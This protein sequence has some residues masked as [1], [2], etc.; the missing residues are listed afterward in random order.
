[1]SSRSRQYTAGICSF[2]TLKY[3]TE[4]IWPEHLIEMWR[5][6]FPCFF[7]PQTSYCFI[8][9]NLISMATLPLLPKSL[10]IFPTMTLR[11]ALMIHPNNS[12][13]SLPPQEVNWIQ[14]CTL[15]DSTQG[16]QAQDG[17]VPFREH[18]TCPWTRKKKLNMSHNTKSITW[19][20]WGDFPELAT[21]G[22][23]TT[24]DALSGSIIR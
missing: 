6:C 19:E 3:S 21:S 13:E 14:S 18:C 2:L 10:F 17:N 16:F 20:E 15:K 1:M 9:P 7:W 12:I 4:S 22:Y 11:K 24:S 23:F 8:S 5:R